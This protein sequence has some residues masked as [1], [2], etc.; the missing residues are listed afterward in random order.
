MWEW[1]TDDTSSYRWWCETVEAPLPIVITVNGGAAPRRPCNAKL[2][3]EIQ[4]RHLPYGTYRR[5]TSS[6]PN[7]SRPTWH[8]T[9]GRWQMSTEMQSSAVWAV[10]LPRSRPCR[11]SCFQAKR[12]RP[13][14][15]SD[16]D[17]EGNDQRIVGWK[18]YRLI[19]QKGLMN[20]VFVYCEIEG[21]TV[22]EVSQELLTK[23][24]KLG[25]HAG[26]SATQR[27]CCRYRHQRARS[28]TDSAL[29]C[30]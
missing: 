18:D 22:A 23:G 21:T 2:G 11:T 13:L 28:E 10:H 30:R 8:W 29:W 17:V 1:S 15:S 4:I 5:H 25:E 3:H 19:K 24:R 26:R 9:S 20:N 27:R 7:E 16:A 12:A 6:G 14:T